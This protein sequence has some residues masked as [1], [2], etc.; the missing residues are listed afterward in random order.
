[1][2]R[3]DKVATE[4]SLAH[5]A[6][7]AE[8]IWHECFP[9]II[10]E[11]QIN[12]MVEKFQSLPAMKRQMS[13]DG[14]EYYFI[15]HDGEVAG[16]TG[17]S[18]ALDERALFLSKLYLKK[19]FRGRSIASKVIDMLADMAKSAKKSGITLTVNRGNE[20]AIALYLH[21]GFVVARCQKADI[22]G[23]YYMDD[24]VMEL[25]L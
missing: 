11:G 10:S 15:M 13:E 21:K 24:Y 22:G 2:I 4:D 8:S 16:Y 5:L 18:A 3:L 12:Y 19:E 25:S 23:G 6:A 7:L 1:M 9:G 14:Y 20:Q 17:I